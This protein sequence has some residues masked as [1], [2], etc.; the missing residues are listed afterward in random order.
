MLRLCEWA[1]AL[2]RSYAV[3]DET[4]DAE[5]VTFEE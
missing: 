2:G 4:P 3:A 5:A 1:F